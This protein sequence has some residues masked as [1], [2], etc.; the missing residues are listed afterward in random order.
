MSTP[1]AVART[2]WK[3]VDG[4]RAVAALVVYL[5]HAYAQCWNPLRDVFPHGV[6]SAFSYSLIAGHLSV[7]V[8]IVV[9]GFCLTLPVIADDDHLA[10][11]ALSFMKRRARRILPPYFGALALCLAL[12]ATIIGRPTGTFWDVP[13]M[14]TRTSIVSHLLLLQDLFATGSINYVFWS[15][16]VEWQIYFLFPLLIWGWQRFGPWAIVTGAL[17]LGYAARMGLANTRIAR[18]HPH[19][20]GMFA[21]G[22]LAAYVA[23]SP[24]GPYESM[25]RKIPWGWTSV[26]GLTVACA[27]TVA[28]GVRASFERFYLLDLPVGV[29]ATSVLV[30]T[31]RAGSS[32]GRVLSWRPLAFLGTFSYSVYLVH[33]P[34]LQVLWQYVLAP[35]GLGPAGAFAFLITLGLAV[36]LAVAYVFFL[37]FEAPFLQRRPRR[38]NAPL[39]A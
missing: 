5:N 9:S 6:L 32:L 17:A 18:A 1:A 8:F 16:A 38:A 12:I 11:G 28:W 7:T 10:G 37:G 4:L 13:T 25:R 36:S 15:I 2:H 19:Y 23:R 27:L 35:L 14:V 20:L 22:M 30:L 34:L 39:P 29:M 21:L 26:A 3:H 24:R 33:A 31:T